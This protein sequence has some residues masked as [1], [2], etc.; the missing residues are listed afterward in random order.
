MVLS[1]RMVLLTLVT[2]ACV[3]VGPV[4]AGK[5][6]ADLELDDVL[7]RP[8]QSIELRAKLESNSATGND[9][10]GARVEF[11]LDGRGLGSALTDDDGV[12]LFRTE[13]PLTGEH[14]LKA[15]FEGNDDYLRAEYLALLAVR[16]ADDSMMVLDIDWTI[17][18]TDN[19]NTVLGS[20]DSPPLREAPEVVGQLARVHAPVYVTARARQLRKR[21][22]SWLH[23]YGFPRGPVFFLEPKRFPTYSEAAYKTSVLVPMKKAFPGLRFGIGNKESDVESHRA[24]GLPC[25]LISAREIPGGVCVTHWGL[26]EAAVAKLLAPQ[27]GLRPH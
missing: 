14:E 18:M 17:S 9:I 3:A 6:L 22:F 10:E 2:F 13:A 24:A 5:N 12:A 4:Q 1:F 20:S 23:R 7:A 11:R 27:R 25:L 15:V 19:L 26:V 8:G 21:T 16:R